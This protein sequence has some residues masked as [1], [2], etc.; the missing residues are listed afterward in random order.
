M[1]FCKLNFKKL[2]LKKLF[3]KISLTELKVWEKTVGEE[4]QKQQRI[5]E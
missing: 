1:L 5:P 2:T 3:E 4:F